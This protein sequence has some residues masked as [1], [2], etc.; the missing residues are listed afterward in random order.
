MDRAGSF[1]IGTIDNYAFRIDLQAPRII[2]CRYDFLRPWVFEDRNGTFWVPDNNV[3]FN[4]VGGILEVTRA[5]LPGGL[6]FTAM[7]EDPEGYL[8]FADNALHKYN[9]RNKSVKPYRLSGKVHEKVKIS[10]IKYLQG[11][12]NGNL[13]FG[14]RDFLAFLNTKTGKDEL[15]SPANF[16]FMVENDWQVE[17]ILS[18]HTI[19]SG[20]PLSKG[21]AVLNR[22]MENG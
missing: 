12:K 4:S 5:Q 10:G 9:P 22:I 15:I 11:D 2:H 8:W 20:L 19:S 6:S 7:Y 16:R 14:N 1:W 3:K 18:I 13:W 17:Q 21:F